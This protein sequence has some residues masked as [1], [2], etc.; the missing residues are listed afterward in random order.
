VRLYIRL[1]V[2]YEDTGCLSFRWHDYSDSDSTH[3]GTISD[4]V[5]EV[6][7]IVL[8]VVVVKL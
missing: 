7:K 3:T 2:K 4:Q 6:T 1:R 5:F 8:F